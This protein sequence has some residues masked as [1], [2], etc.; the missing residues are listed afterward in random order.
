M[1]EIR[2][3]GLKEIPP[4]NFYSEVPEW[5]TAGIG[6]NEEN[7]LTERRGKFLFSFQLYFLI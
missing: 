3:N 6:D 2:I 5:K 4:V 1:A 7:L